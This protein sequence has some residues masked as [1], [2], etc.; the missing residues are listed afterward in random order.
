MWR[1]GRERERKHQFIFPGATDTSA[2]VDSHEV[3]AVATVTMYSY[4]LLSNRYFAQCFGHLFG[5]CPTPY[6]LCPLSAKKLARPAAG[7]DASIGPP[8][9][10]R[11]CPY[12]IGS[13]S[14]IVCARPLRPCP[15]AVRATGHDSYLLT[16]I[17]CMY[18]CRRRC[19]S[20]CKKEPPP[21]PYVGS[22]SHTH[23]STETCRFIIPHRPDSFPL[24][25]DR[26][27]ASR[28]EK[29]NK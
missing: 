2:R 27:A 8:S 25:M 22:H 3:A 26:T 23:S 1:C 18:R 12:L 20:E 14:D 15:P 24:R 4:S 21:N 7:H 17:P 28:Q 11:G 29:I 19:L 16:Y 13:A 6:G 9:T 5:H 10:C